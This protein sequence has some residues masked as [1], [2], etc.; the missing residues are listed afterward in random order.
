MKLFS[1]IIENS[2]RMQMLSTVED[3][4]KDALLC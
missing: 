3:V 2:H 4:L 1:Y